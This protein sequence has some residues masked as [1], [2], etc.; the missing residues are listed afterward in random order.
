MRARRA[1][2]LAVALTLASG[3]AA[4]PASQAATKKPAPVKIFPALVVNLRAG[5]A[6]VDPALRSQ[7]ALAD[8]QA[9]ALRHQGYRLAVISRLPQLYP[10]LALTAREVLARLPKSVKFVGI[11]YKG[12]LAG[13]TRLPTV[14]PADVEL[15]AKQAEAKGLPSK[16]AMLSAFADIV[17]SGKFV[18]P[19]TGGGGTPWWQWLLFVLL[20]AAVAA[21][22][23]LGYRHYRGAQEAGRRRRGGSILTAREFHQERLD[24]LSH[25]HSELV[26]GVAEHGEDSALAGHHQTAGNKLVALRRQLTQLYA[27]RELRTC[28]LE[29]DEIEWHVETCEAIL[30]GAG[31]PPKP[32]ADHHGLCFFTHEHGLAA[33]DVDV[34]KPDGTVATV[35]VCPVNALALENGEPPFVSMVPVGSRMVP[36]PAAP[37]W[38]GAAGWSPE[39]LPGLEHRGHEIWGREAPVRLDAP[40]TTTGDRLLPGQSPPP[41][42]DLPDLPPGV[43][44][45]GLFDQDSDDVTLPPPADAPDGG[46]RRFTRPEPEAGDDDGLPPGVELPPEATGDATAE[47]PR[48]S[49]APLFE[50]LDRPHVP[51]LI[52]EDT[53][54]GDPHDAS[55]DGRSDH[56]VAYDPFADEQ[57]DDE[58]RRRG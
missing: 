37:T 15:A 7:V 39:D 36:W 51:G 4:A 8:L 53:G 5:V 26:R 16:V 33:V 42:R 24:A 6:W 43:T 13:A 54:E 28:A 56:T 32:S 17:A 38:Y 21:G 10:N 47:V 2:I 34:T 1:L 50:E 45:P 35:R 44:A 19:G 58:R 30:A 22:L 9:A 49:G 52:D 12:T 48:E 14:Q 57:D 40:P 3:L 55:R 29:L 31:L 20:L 11:E 27:P 18:K 41:P 25:R 23:L 46:A